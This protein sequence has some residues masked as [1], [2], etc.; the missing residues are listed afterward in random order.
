MK[1]VLLFA[2]MA[3][4]A[5][6]NSSSPAATAATKSMPDSTMAEIK[7]PYA[8]G[9][10]SKFVMDDPRNAETVLQLWKDWDAG[11]LMT[12]KDMF[13]DTVTLNLADGTTM[14]GSKDSIMA[15]MQQFR[16]SLAASVSQV[17]AIMAVKS[18]DKDENW[19]LVWGKEINT[20]K[21]GKTD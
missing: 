11:N 3:F 2:C 1:N 8:I 12:S 20:D 14:H 16:N 7:S 17:N 15:N 4:L 6:C 18:T 9:Y 21:K 19:A 5:A 10:S 13:A